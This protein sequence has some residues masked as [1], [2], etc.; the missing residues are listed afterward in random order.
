[1]PK[2]RHCICEALYEARLHRHDCLSGG[3]T[4]GVKQR[5]EGSTNNK[6]RSQC[7]LV[8]TAWHVNGAGDAF[9]VAFFSELT[10]RAD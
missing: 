7:W 6:W 8:L 4:R 3:V 2:A 9:C 1:M 5:Q 10:E